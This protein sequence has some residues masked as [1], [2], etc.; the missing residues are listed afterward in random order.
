MIDHKSRFA[1]VNS[2]LRS[3]F[4]KIVNFKKLKGSSVQLKNIF[5]SKGHLSHFGHFW[6]LR[7]FVP[8]HEWI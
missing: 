8:F 2:V 1:R 4:M 6:Q 3:S 7:A 5:R